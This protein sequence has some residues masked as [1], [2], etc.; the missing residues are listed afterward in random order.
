MSK[1]THTST[2]QPPEG[3]EVKRTAKRMGRILSTVLLAVSTVL[4]VVVVLRSAVGK[5]ASFFGYRLFYVVTGSMEPTL[6][7]GS[8]LI[9]GESDEYAIDDIITF[10]SNDTGI[11]G[12]PNTHRIIDI[13]EKDG[14]IYYITQGDANN[15]PD[16]PIPRSD[17]IGKM[18]LC[19]DLSGLKDF[20][21][22][23]GTPPGFFFVIILPLMAVMVICMR[24][25]K[26]AMSEELRRAAM[27]SLEE[28]TQ[29]KE[30]SDQDEAE[31]NQTK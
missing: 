29:P 14:Q 28:E 15:I 22:F 31:G 16:D 25:F 4:C 10:Y 2:P 30:E 17:V 8:M 19:I 5:D 23:L 18:H 21:A 13:E 24:D 7:V 20:V 11:E 26:R 27:E 6:P 3:Q 9:V 12:Q 1:R